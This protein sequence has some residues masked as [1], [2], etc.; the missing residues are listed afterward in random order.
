M[1][2]RLSRIMSAATAAYGVYALA[3]PAHIGKAM[4]AG[5]KEQAH[6]DTLARVYGVRDVAISVLGVVG[7]PGAV[8]AAMRLRVASDLVDAAY[9]SARTDDGKV[10]AKVL[11]ATLGWAAL[12]SLAVARDRRR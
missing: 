2:H 12:N 8:R 4:E 7:S 11:G 6:Y 3:R 10:R 5:P 1:S 9:L